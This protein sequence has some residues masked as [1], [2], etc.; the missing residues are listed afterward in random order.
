MDRALSG[1]LGAQTQALAETLYK[2]ER[3]LLSIRR[4]HLHA[5]KKHISDSPGTGHT[6][7]VLYL[8]SVYETARCFPILSE[9]AEM[10]AKLIQDEERES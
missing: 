1:A 5:A 4:V 9:V 6:D 8:N 3:A 2:Y 7:G 10:R